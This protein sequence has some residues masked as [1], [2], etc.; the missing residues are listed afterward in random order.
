MDVPFAWREHQGAPFP[1]SCLKLSV[2]GIPLVKL[3]AEVGASLTASLRTDGDPRPLGADR[4]ASLFRCCEYVSAVL[5]EVPLDPV[6]RSYFER[7]EQL[8]TVVLSVKG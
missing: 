4:R 1:F 3:D 2:A 8:A 6:A 5:R 7:L